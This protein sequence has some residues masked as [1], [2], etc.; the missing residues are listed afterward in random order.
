M[1][2]RKPLT[3]S[4][5]TYPEPPSITRLRERYADELPEI[6]AFDDLAAARASRPVLDP[7]TDLVALLTGAHPD[8]IASVEAEMT[9]LRTV[10]RDR[11]DALATAAWQMLGRGSDVT[12]PLVKVGDDAYL[13]WVGSCDAPTGHV[14]TEAEALTEGFPPE[15][16]AAAEDATRQTFYNRGGPGEC[17]LTADALREAHASTE[18]RAAFR[19]TPDKVL[20]YTTADM[21]Q[22]PETGTWETGETYWVPWHPDEVPD[23]LPDSMQDRF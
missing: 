17:A 3:I 8:A 10:E 2:R 1:R 13:A 16:V 11:L 5:A 22:N 19:L 4:A 7:D 9:R 14:M 20:P 21:V 6:V 23:A 12:R 18:S 15:R